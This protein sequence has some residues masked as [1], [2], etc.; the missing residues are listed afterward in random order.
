[1]NLIA[2]R[3]CQFLEDLKL[4]KVCL[5][6]QVKLSGLELKILLPCVNGGKH[7]DPSA[8]CDLLTAQV[9]GSSSRIV[10]PRPGRGAGGGVEGTPVVWHTHIKCPK[11]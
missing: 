9:N 8:F 3:H 5:A 6:H 1:M 4:C 10:E 2:C 11:L 7:E